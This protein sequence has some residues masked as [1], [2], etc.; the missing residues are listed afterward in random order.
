MQ[1]VRVEWTGEVRE[2]MGWRRGLFR[3]KM[4]G[5]WNWKDGVTPP[6]GQLV[7]V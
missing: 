4:T 1:N 5:S 3:E 6:N 2:G 7:L